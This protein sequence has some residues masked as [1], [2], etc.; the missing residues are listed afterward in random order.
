MSITFDSLYDGPAGTCPVCGA[1]TD[2]GHVHHDGNTVTITRDDSEYF[3]RWVAECSC[4][5]AHTAGRERA[6]YTAGRTHLRTGWRQPM[7]PKRAV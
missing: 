6:A 4:G 2:N 3:P 7:P 1:P 5:W